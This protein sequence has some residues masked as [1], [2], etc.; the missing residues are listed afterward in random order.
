[1]FLLRK[2]GGFVLCDVRIG[3]LSAANAKLLALSQERQKQNNA[4]FANYKVPAS[5]MAYATSNSSGGGTPN[6]FLFQ[7]QQFDPAS[8]TYYLR[9]RNYAP[10]D[11]RFLSPDPF[12]GKDADPISLHRYLYASND[13]VNRIDPG[14]REDLASLSIGEAESATLDGIN[15]GAIQGAKAFAKDA[16][17]EAVDAESPQAI[18]ERGAADSAE[19]VATDLSDIVDIGN[20]GE[21][22]AEEQIPGF[23]KNTE[24]ITDFTGRR[25]YRIPDQLDRVNKIIGE[26]KNVKRLDFRSQIK[27]D[28]MFAEKYGY[29][30]RLYVRPGVQLAPKIQEAIDE[31]RIVL[32]YLN[33]P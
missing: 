21:A 17:G 28:L 27:N 29:T 32:Q 2:P 8:N 5:R 26:V 15:T 33:L 22:A 11:G 19:E 16:I 30:F 3:S 12:D 7:G 1:M 23:V 24:H 9:A 31:G 14:G 10:T 25:A 6:P 20:D 4:S 13:P 18:A